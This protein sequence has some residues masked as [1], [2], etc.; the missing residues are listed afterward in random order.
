M[1]Q[2]ANPVAIPMR[3]ARLVNVM[4]ETPPS[5]A[6][7][8]RMDLWLLEPINITPKGTGDIFINPVSSGALAI[9]GNA[10]N[11]G[12]FRIFEDT[13]LGSYHTGFTAGNLTE[14]IV[15]TLPLADAGTSGDALT[16]NAS[17]TLSW[18]TISG[19]TSWQSVTTGT[20][21]TTVAGSGY[22]INTT[23]N[24]CTA[25]LPAG[26]VGD[27]VSFIDYART[28][29]SNNLTVTANGSEKI[30]A[31]TDDLTNAVEGAGFTLVYVDAT[32]GWLLKDK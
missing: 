5:F 9:K 3:P 11:A 13:D 2:R 10:T 29:D 27:E 1:T 19:G 23:S 12:I 32:Q 24:V 22:P 6:L 26:T 17:G 15:Y 20:T 31:S 7:V 30:Y 25:T 14:D 4:S 8:Q 28:F 21:V 18:T 16:S